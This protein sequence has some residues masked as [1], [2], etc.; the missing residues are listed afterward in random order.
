MP[1]FLIGL[2]IPVTIG[3]LALFSSDF[4]EI[5]DQIPLRVLVGSQFFRIFGCVFFLV[6]STGIGPK[7]FVASGYGD[8]ITGFLACITAWMLYKNIN[9][10]TSAVWAFSIVGLLDLFNVSR[11]L[12]TNYPTWSNA[13]PS[14]ACAGSFPLML[15]VGLA[16]P[17]A[18]LLH[19]YTIRALVKYRA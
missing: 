19:V 3:L 11:I 15:V 6:A 2:L 13:N 1:R 5:L 4:G 14:T 10:A 17:V 9:G 8:M 12:L 16:A 7:E 18:L